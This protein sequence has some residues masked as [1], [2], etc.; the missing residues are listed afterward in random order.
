LV[1]ADGPQKGQPVIVEQSLHQIAIT[2]R[3]IILADIAFK[4]EFSQIFS[5]FLLDF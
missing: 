3:F 1:L 2:E 4:M 5:P